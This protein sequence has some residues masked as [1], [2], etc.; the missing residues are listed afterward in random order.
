MM[1]KKV[2]AGFVVLALIAAAIF[3]VSPAGAVDFAISGQINRAA[4]YADDGKSAEWFFVD[5]DNS[6]TRFRF[7]GSNDFTHDMSVGIV[8]EVEMQSNPS[9]EMNMNQVGDTSPV[10]FNE[11]KIE[12]WVG[13]PW[14]KV[15]MGQGDMASNSTSEVDLSG[16]S[17]AAYSSVGDVGGGF[18]FQNN[19]VYTG[20]T[21]GGSRSNFDGLSRKD[22]VRYV[23]PKLAGFYASGSVGNSSIWDTALRYAGDFGWAKLAAA[24]AWSDYGTSSSTNDNIFSSSASILFD[25]GLNFTASYAYRKQDNTDPYN[26]FGKVGYQF[27]EKHAVSVQYSRTKNLSAKDD[28][29]DTFGIGYVYSPWKSV[30]FY[31]TYYLYMLDLDMGSNPDDINVGMIGGRVKF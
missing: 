13:S 25:F 30:E 11:R 18:V 31:G 16:T 12:F 14:G 9:N 15:W 2:Q 3:A 6:S 8:W 17:V 29:G 26:I 28:K 5:N 24:A 19:G 22:R 7:T 20:V 4:L 21:V 23:T 27:L 1:Q 10:N